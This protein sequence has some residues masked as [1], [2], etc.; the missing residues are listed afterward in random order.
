MADMNQE[1]IQQKIQVAR[2]DAEALKDRIKRKKDELA[3][4]TLRDVA[5]DRVEALPRLAMKTKR[6][7]KG[8]LAKI[9]AMHWSTDRR[10][11]VSASQDGKLIIWDA[12]T[13]N[14][15]HAIPLRSSWVMTCAYSP[16]GNYVACGGLDNICSIYN[17]SAREGPTRVAR[18]LS[19]H[20]GYLS[21]CRF[22]SDKRILT[23]SGDMT[24]V[25]W[26]LETGSKVHEFA[27]HLGDVMSLSINPLDHNQFVSGACDAFA[28]L[29]D[30]RQ[31]KCVQTFAA[32]DSDINAIQFFPNG[33]AFGTGSD[34]AS[35]RLFDIRA[36]RELAS[37]QIPEP[38]CGITSVAFSVS[39]RLLFAGY[40]DFECKV[41]DV[42]RGERVGTLQGHDNRVSC[43]GVSNDALSLCTGSWDSMLRIWA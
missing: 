16:S 13:T 31:Q 5:R 12:Y 26:D 43:L 24:C 33:N 3:D 14:K 40:D 36:D 30:I 19:G 17:L 22:I 29:W 38:V 27:D 7:L 10:H 11:L 2:R 28:K 20:S 34:D 32:H 8:H 9:Y 15:V 23:S 21:C 6:T 42:L 35:C 1:S 4:T 25:L 39:G 41:W 37:Y 18:E